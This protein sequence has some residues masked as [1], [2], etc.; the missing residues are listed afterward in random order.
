MPA[1][2]SATEPPPPVILSGEDHDAAFE[3][4]ISRRELGHG[5]LRGLTAVE[6]VHA[7]TTDADL[8]SMGFSDTRKKLRRNDNI[9]APARPLVGISRT[10]L[11]LVRTTTKRAPRRL[12]Y[13]SHTR[14]VRRG[15][16]QRR[17]LVLPFGAKRPT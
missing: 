3:I 1:A 11:T 13:F 7:A 4:K 6:G 15:H 14:R 2:A 16:F 10:K 8:F 17:Y 9:V 5:L 12:E